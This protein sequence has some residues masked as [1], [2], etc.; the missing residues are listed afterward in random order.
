LDAK[1]MKKIKP[2]IRAGDACLNNT[3]NLGTWVHKES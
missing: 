3:S 2:E 1:R